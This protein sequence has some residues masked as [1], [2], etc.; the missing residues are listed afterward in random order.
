[1]VERGR[2]R[3]NDQTSQPKKSGFR[4]MSFEAAL[5]RAQAFENA[6]MEVLRES[7]QMR[8]EQLVQE[9]TTRLGEPVLP[10]AVTAVVNRF[11]AA[12]KP[13]PRKKSGGKAA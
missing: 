4:D 1:M 8:T 5:F 9:L 7:P 12:K 10:G 11:L 2:K 3:I 6:V 13:A